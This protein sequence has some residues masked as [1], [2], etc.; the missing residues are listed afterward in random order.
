VLRILD[1]NF[2]IR[3]GKFGAYVFYKKKDMQKPEFLNI[4][5][6]NGGFMTCEKDTLL[7]WLA[8]TYNLSIK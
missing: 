4:K 8:E 7:Q 2:S 6:F 5:K 1:E 3:K